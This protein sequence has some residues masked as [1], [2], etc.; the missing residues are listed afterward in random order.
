MTDD[1][2][3]RV[4][5]ERDKSSRGLPWG[6][7]DEL[8]AEVE[9]LHTW[10]GL[11]SLLDEHWPQSIFPTLSDDPGRDPGPRI[12]SLL[13]WVEHLRALQRDDRQ[14]AINAIEERDQAVREVERLQSDLSFYREWSNELTQY[15]PE[16][17]DDDIAQ[18]AIIS[19]WAKFVSAEVER[20]RGALEAL[21][22]DLNAHSQTTPDDDDHEIICDVESAIAYR[23]E[24]VLR[25][26]Q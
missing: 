9:R 20:L 16:E 2:T 6:L 4:R 12:V 24:A 3:D 11:M 22:H 5:A 1:V 14:N 23:I 25:G 8:L 13:R 19:N 15:I 17:F 18:E 10:D 21:A 26:D 7:A